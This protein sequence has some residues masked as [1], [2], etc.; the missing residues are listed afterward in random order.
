M[1]ASLLAEGFKAYDPLLSRHETAWMLECP[2]PPVQRLVETHQGTGGFKRNR[3][4]VYPAWTHL[5]NHEQPRRVQ[6]GP[7]LS[8][9]SAVLIAEVKA[10]GHSATNQESHPNCTS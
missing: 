2:A 4:C 10:E 1:T 8:H 3:P 6:H 7:Q 9:G 5:I